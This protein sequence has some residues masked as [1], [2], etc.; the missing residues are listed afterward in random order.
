M[1]S[2]SGPGAADARAALA[3][4]QQDPSGPLVPV[5]RGV[6]SVFA[7]RVGG[8]T[9][10][11]RLT[12]SGWRTRADI[13]EELRFVSHLGAHGIGVAE[14]LPALSGRSLEAT[15][16]GHAVCFRRAPGVFVRPDALERAPMLHAWGAALAQMHRAAV[17]FDAPRTGWR[18]DWRREPV[19]IDGLERLHATD[20]ESSAEADAILAELD[21][22]QHCLGPKAMI[23]ADFAPQNFRFA[24]GTLTAFDFDNACVHWAAYDLAVARSVLRRRPGGLASFD[25][26]VAGY[27]GIADLPC[28]GEAIDLLERLR[29][30]Y[31]L[32]DRVMAAKRV[33]GSDT[34]TATSRAR[35]LA[36]VRD[37]L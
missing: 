17:T 12:A 2:G 9:A 22:R 23:H 15:D 4:W 27:E 14:A 11:L 34:A 8:H 7:A 31:V 28:S 3:L 26:I 30:L 36:H 29:A 25:R 19:L 18:S 35:F 21:A 24:R 10:F 1:L 5:S 16:T 13:E 20:P 6:N 32:C 33:P 37:G